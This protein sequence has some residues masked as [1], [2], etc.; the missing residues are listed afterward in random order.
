MLLGRWNTVWIDAFDVIP[1]S[2]NE[3]IANASFLNPTP[4]AMRRNLSALFSTASFNYDT[5]IKPNAIT[6]QPLIS[7]CIWAADTYYADGVKCIH[8]RR[9]SIQ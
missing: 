7:S 6:K 5:F 8:W 4:I 3:Y 2:T 9:S 1:R